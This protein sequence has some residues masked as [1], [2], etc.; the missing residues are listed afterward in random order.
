M[1][2]S[3]RE[4]SAHSYEPRF[5][6]TNLLNRG[7]FAASNALQF[8][9][10]ALHPTTTIALIGC[11]PVGL[12]ALIS[13]LSFKPAKIFAIDSVPSRLAL[14][15]SLGAVPLNFLTDREQ[16]HTT[17]LEAT[18]GRGV[19]AVMEVVGNSPALRMAYDIVRPWGTISSVGVHNTE[20]PITGNE[21]YNKNI[22][23]QFGRC[24]VRAIFPKALELLEEKHQL[25]G[26]VLLTPTQTYVNLANVSNICPR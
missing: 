8:I 13:A 12:C 17:I 2:S 15:K 6:L 19:D 18:N 11:G 1:I 26:Y 7:Y 9:P 16:L 5:Q 4:S 21:M 24:P 14:A 23:I 3:Q 20:I 22:R 10:P 25:L